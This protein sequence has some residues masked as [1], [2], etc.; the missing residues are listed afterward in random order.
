LKTT[1]NT[2]ALKLQNSAMDKLQ[3]QT[4]EEIYMTDIN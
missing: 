2:K 1:K 4:D 3:S